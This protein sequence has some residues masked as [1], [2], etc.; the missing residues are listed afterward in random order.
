MTLGLLVLKLVDLLGL[1]ATLGLLAL[2]WLLVCLPS[3]TRVCLRSH[4]L[5]PPELP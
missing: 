2:T 1:P 5:G 3:H 4:T